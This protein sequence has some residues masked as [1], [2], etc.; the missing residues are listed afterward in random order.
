MPM[1][2]RPPLRITSDQKLAFA[3]VACTLLCLLFPVAAPLFLSLFVG[4]AVR[5]AGLKRTSARCSAK[6]SSTAPPSS[7]A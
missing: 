2:E 1:P 5:E 3:V 6:P 4:V 7:S